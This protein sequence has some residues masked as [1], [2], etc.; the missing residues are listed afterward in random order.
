MRSFAGILVVLLSVPLQVSFTTLTGLHCDL[1]LIAIYF[2]GLYYG[3]SAD[4][5]L[6]RGRHGASRLRPESTVSHGLAPGAR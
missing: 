4:R 5:G 2:C 1:S 3:K 6:S